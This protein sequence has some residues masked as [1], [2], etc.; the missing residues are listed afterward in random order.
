MSEVEPIRPK[1][2]G[3]R[4]ECSATDP[5]KDIAKRF[6]ELLTAVVK[7]GEDRGYDLKTCQVRISV[8]CERG[9]IEVAEKEA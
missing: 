5:P 6:A 7:Y 2:V 4:L 8:E 9:V 3:A 1:T